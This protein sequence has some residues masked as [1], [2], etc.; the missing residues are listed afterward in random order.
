MRQQY[1]RVSR[2][3]KESQ[4]AAENAQRIAQQA[5]RE[6][7]AA[8]Q[9]LAAF[10]ERA[11][12][13]ERL[14]ANAH[15]VASDL[16]NQQA[17]LRELAQEHLRDHQTIELHQ[18]TITDMRREITDRARH[19]V[20]ANRLIQR[21]RHYCQ[22]LG[23]AMAL[24]YPALRQIEPVAPDL[25][26]GQLMKRAEEIV[27][28]MR[29]RII[30]LQGPGT[31]V[32]E[33]LDGLRVVGQDSETQTEDGFFSSSTSDSTTGGA[34]RF[35]SVNT[36]IPPPS[37]APPAPRSP[38]AVWL[39]PTFPPPGIIQRQGSLATAPSSPSTPTP[40]PGPLS[41]HPPTYQDSRDMVDY[42]LRLSRYAEWASAQ[43]L[44]N[45]DEPLGGLV[46]FFYD[47]LPQECRIYLVEQD[48]TWD[49]EGVF[50]AAVTWEGRQVMARLAQA[51]SA[52]LAATSRPIT[53]GH[54]RGLF[55]NL[56]PP[57]LTLPLLPDSLDR[58]RDGS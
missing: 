38:T 35:P 36:A 40:S 50:G 18:R 55:H 45:L 21:Y 44:V 23:Q 6:R 32:L 3:L 12:R 29:D 27:V 53:L 47:G 4:A 2:T 39:P 1:E 54:P 24:L 22:Y 8:R 14:E 7:D 43:G 48:V 31:P 42:R 58:S 34:V 28:Q 52:T 5:L 51:T 46:T 11:Q 26:P 10:Q 19:L 33:A 16:Q 15:Q 41:L 17:E 30:Q 9:E 13:S 25:T 20:Q 56:V 57:G 37:L 49:M